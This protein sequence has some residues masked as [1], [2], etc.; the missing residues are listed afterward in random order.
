M[1]KFVI[2]YNPNSGDGK[3][4]KIA[5]EIENHMGQ[6][7][8]TYTDVTK[9]NDFTAFFNSLPNN[10]D[11]VLS[12]GDG[13]LNS[14]INK[15]DSINI[16]QNIYFYASGS[17]NDFAR[18]IGFKKLT[19]PIKINKYIENL[20]KAYIN[21]ENY[22]FINCVGSGMD[23]YCCH[24]VE[25]LRA[26]SKR[27]ANYVLVA[28]KAL[29]Y[30][31]KPCTAYVTVDEN[32]YVFKNA[33]LVPTMNGKYFGGGFMAAPKQDRLN[34]DHTLSLVAMHSKN[35]FKIIIAFLLIFFGKHTKLKS[36]IT[37]IEGHK[38]SVKLSNTAT[39]QIDGETIENVKEYEIT[40]AKELISAK[41]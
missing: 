19:K 11:I 5:Q 16:T 25:R 7:L 22:K 30:A 18:D 24:E 39:L 3:G 37:V 41:N 9:I 34:S 26:I 1:K 28:I 27:R 2:L 36:M 35:I 29:L 33:W 32:N 21:G 38:I 4:L 12:G 23:G 20:P 10:T 8:Y 31:Y 15:I 40:S 14:F 17:G 13:T 6:N